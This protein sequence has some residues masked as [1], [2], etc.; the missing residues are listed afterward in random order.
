MKKIRMKR[1]VG[2]AT[3]AVNIG[4]EVDVSDARGVA[5]VR[6]GVAED[7]T[8]HD[9]QPD[10]EEAD[11]SEGDSLEALNVGE[12][13]ERLKASGQPTEGKKAELVERLRNIQP[14]DEGDTDT[15]TDD[16]GEG[17]GD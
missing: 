6:Q 9:Y 14:D 4:D 15:E 3:G 8:P 10:P 7:I 1:S 12:L 11:A 13:R 2:T 17:D 16:A 5:W